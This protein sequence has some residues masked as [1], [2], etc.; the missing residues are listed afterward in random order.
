MKKIYR[1]PKRWTANVPVVIGESLVEEEY[2]FRRRNTACRNARYLAKNPTPAEK[3]FERILNNLN[4]GVLRGK[5]F[6]QWVLY[7]K[8]ILDFFFYENRLAVEIDGSF[9]DRLDQIERDKEKDQD[10]KD[11][12][13]TLIRI[14]N[15][16][17]FGDREELIAKLRRGWR[18]ASKKMKK[19]HFAL[20]CLP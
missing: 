8:W 18:K 17:V 20:Q 19:S 12:H 10:C 1:K 2:R 6:T 5:F 13:V 3:E 15:K 11:K 9:H 4:G 14:S 7:D 16:E